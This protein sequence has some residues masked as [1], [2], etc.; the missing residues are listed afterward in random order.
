MYRVN[1]V[2]PSEVTNSEFDFSYTGS[3]QEFTAPY[4]GSYKIELWG[5]QGGYRGAITN[6]GYGGYTTATIHMTPNDKLYIYVGGSGQSGMASGGWN[7]G[8]SRTTSGLP[9]GGGATDVRTVDTGTNWSD[10][11]SLNSRLLV[12][13]GGGSGGAPSRPGGYGGGYN[14]ESRTQSY[15]SGGGGGTQS[16]GGSGGSNNSGTF[17]Q[18]GQG[19]YRANGYGGAGGGGWYGGGG[20]YPDGSV[21]DDRGGGGGSSYIL[22]EDS[23]KPSG[24]LL[25]AEDYVLTDGQTISGNSTMPNPNGGYMTGRTGNGYARITYLIPPSSNNLLDSIE[26]TSGELDGGYDYD[27]V[28]YNV[29]L[30]SEVTEIEIRG[31]V[32]DNTA[33]IE[34]NGVYDTPAGETPVQ[35]TVTAEDGS[36]RIYTITFIK[37]ASED[38]TVEDI[39]ISGFVPSLCS[40]N[41]NYCNKIYD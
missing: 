16:S 13:G 23:Y 15:G 21:D 39:V 36:I 1:V 38:T 2:K 41:E 4:Y 6:G 33:T 8:G 11:T 17:G 30:D 37:E 40:L 28:D 3:A 9:G 12:A 31:I 25:S 34:G 22:T 24:Y 20:V 14:G 19:L 18:G 27:L 5:A 29:Y 35:L 7:G 32:S 26:L 10:T